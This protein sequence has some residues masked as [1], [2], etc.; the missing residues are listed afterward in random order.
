MALEALNSSNPPMKTNESLM[1]TKKKRSK[2][3]RLDSPPSE[4]EY[5][6]L[7]LVMLAR[8]AT[9]EEKEQQQQQQQRVTYKCGVCDKEFLS[10]QALGGHKASHRKPAVVDGLHTVIATTATAMSSSSTSTGGGKSH[11]CTICN[12]SFPSGQALGGHKR[13]HYEGGI[14]NINNNKSI[15]A[16]ATATANAAA[17]STVSDGAAATSTVTHSRVDFDLNLPAFPDNHLTVDFDGVIKQA[18]FD[19]EVE[20]PHP[21][22]KPRPFSLH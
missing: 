19:Q 5:L 4:E 2:R 8:G 20:S 9:S 3:P 12:K 6:A 16:T 14:S 7:C 22:K 21:S 11:V 13:C 10:Y 18:C 1:M 17:N 15:S